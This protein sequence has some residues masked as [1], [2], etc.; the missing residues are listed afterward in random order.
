MGI[1]AEARRQLEQSKRL[2]FGPKNPNPKLQKEWGRLE[3]QWSEQLFAAAQSLARRFGGGGGTRP[4]DVIVG[5]EF[6]IGSG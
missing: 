4:L 5:E 1:F 6:S 2:K 3:A